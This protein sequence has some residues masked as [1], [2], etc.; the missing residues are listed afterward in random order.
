MGGPRFTSEEMKF[1]IDNYPTHTI[2]WCA[3][4]LGKTRSSICHKLGSMD[5]LH[6]N[7]YKTRRWTVEENRFLEDNYMNH[8]A[9]WCSNQIRRTELAVLVHCHY[10]GIN[11]IHLTP[12]KS[13]EQDEVTFLVENYPD[14]GIAYCSKELGRTY[15]SV[16]AKVV[17]LGL[18]RNRNY[19]SADEDRIL[20]ENCG[21]Y[22]DIDEMKHLLPGRSVNAIWCRC[23][24][25][26]YSNT[27]SQPWKNRPRI[28][29]LIIREV[30][31]RDNRS[32]ASCGI[33]ADSTILELHHNITWKKCKEHT[34]DNI[35]LLCHKCHREL[36]RDRCKCSN[37]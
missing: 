14:S 33:T 17:R 25:L 30:Y 36:H 37:F 8:S 27:L 16:S 23:K 1:L 21:Y 22:T 13:W 10:L 4:Q 24:K 18:H 15:D 5:M 2:V 29:Y 20:L 26:R 9:R 32:C 31:E 34:V 3:Q 19:W 6:K 35:I 7:K 12:E 28:P 11:K